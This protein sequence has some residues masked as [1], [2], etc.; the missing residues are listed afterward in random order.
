MPKALN[1]IADGSEEFEFVTPYDGLSERGTM[2]EIEERRLLMRNNFHG[3]GLGSQVRRRESRGRSICAVRL[4]LTR[5]TDVCCGRY[6]A[7][8]HRVY[9]HVYPS[10]FLTSPT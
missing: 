8:L 4:T 5:P 7:S 1:L 6:E 2:Y 9:F 10:P 3:S